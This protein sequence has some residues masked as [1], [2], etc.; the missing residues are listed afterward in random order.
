MTATLVGPYV[1]A[2]QDR[3]GEQATPDVLALAEALERLSSPDGWTGEG[4]EVL[5][6]SGLDHDTAKAALGVLAPLRLVN[7]PTKDAE[8]RRWR[9]RYEPPAEELSEPRVWT[10]KPANQNQWA[11]RVW[12]DYHLSSTQKLILMGLAIE[13]GM[14]VGRSGKPFG[15]CTT[16]AANSYIRGHARIGETAA[17]ENL[18][19]VV[20]AGWLRRLDSGKG[21][22][23]GKGRAVYL[24]TLPA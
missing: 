12:N 21:G 15:E 7:V 18:A 24:P 4:Q 20:A 2:V 3:L 14:E 8:D 23:G 11:L 19:A 5:R 13:F 1:Q 22:R 10:R 17:R 16:E 9:I 6:E